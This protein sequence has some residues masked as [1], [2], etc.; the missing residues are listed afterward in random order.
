VIS[1][2]RLG[3]HPS[4]SNAGVP[5]APD[6]DDVYHPAAGAWAQAQHVFLAGNALPE[7]WQ[8]RDRFVIL[9]TGFGLGNNFLATWAAWKADSNHCKRLFFI[10]IEKHPLTLDDLRRVH[11]HSTDPMHQQL[12]EQLCQAWPPLTAGIH[13]LDFDGVTLMLVLGDAQ[14]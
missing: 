13:L 11:G 5:F 6:F 4:E 14:E 10:S 3:A 2:A 12:A 1:P 9:E 7:R 8:G